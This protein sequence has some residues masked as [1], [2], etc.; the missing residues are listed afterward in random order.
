MA[1][2]V[3]IGA[4]VFDTLM[5][6]NGFPEEDTKMQ[7]SQTMIQGGGPCATALV[8]VRK[9][10]VSAEYMGN[11]G[12]DSYGMF[13]LEDFRKYGVETRNIHVK[14]GCDSFHSFVLLNTKQSTRTCIWDK[15]TVP[16]PMPVDIDMDAVCNAKVLH[17][18]GHQLDAA[19]HAAR[20][21]KQHGV[22]VSLD[23]G[24]TYPGIERLLPFIDF[25]IPSEEFA[26]KITGQ[27][28]AEAAATALYAQYKPE[29]LVITQ[30]R[31]GGFL[32]DGK[33]YTHYPAFPVEAIDSNGAGDVFHGA[34][35]AAYVRGLAPL[36]CA[37]L[38][39]A[40]SALK[41]THLGARDGIPSFERTREFMQARLAQMEAMV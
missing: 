40:A 13:M 5:L 41:C 25:L 23:A 21:A 32:Y 12:D 22:K 10:G 2:V 8:A 29:L 31:R 18:D 27:S 35:I 28:T 24:G 17:L 34:F 36:E 38:A 16:P 33:T 26:R 30:G 39:S 20:L 14:I 1:D 11:V 19:I 4:T 7:A 6:T 15:G 3:G 37:K 9:L